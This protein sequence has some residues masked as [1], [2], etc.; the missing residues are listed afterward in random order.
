MST[1]QASDTATVSGRMQLA[2]SLL[3]GGFAQLPVYPYDLIPE[4][5]ACERS[6]LLLR[7]RSLSSLV[8][9]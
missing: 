1:R 9:L 8:R 2:A 3:K 6:G 7:L 5:I 4:V